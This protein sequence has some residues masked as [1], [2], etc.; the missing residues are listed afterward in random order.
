MKKCKICD[1][2]IESGKYCSMCEMKS[3]I[4]FGKSLDKVI[5]TKSKNAA[6]EAKKED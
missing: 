6:K 3:K 1:R 2:P 5:D 4:L